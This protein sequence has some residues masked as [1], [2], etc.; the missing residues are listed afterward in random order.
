MPGGRPTAFTCPKCQTRYQV[1]KGE[2][3]PETVDHDVAC[4]SCGAPFPG[5]DGEFIL[6]YF[7]LRKP[8]RFE[9]RRLTN[10]DREAVK[11][12]PGALR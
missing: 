8:A 2:R 7:V 3:G 9:S 5:R 1:V 10:F 4:R 12:L 11:D 6:K